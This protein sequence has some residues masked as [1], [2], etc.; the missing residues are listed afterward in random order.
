[1][2]NK[3]THMCKADTFAGLIEGARTSKELEYT[4]SIT[5]RNTAAIVAHFYR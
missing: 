5:L 2:A 3:R 4:L 1:V